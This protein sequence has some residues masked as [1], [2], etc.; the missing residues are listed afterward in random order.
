MMKKTRR[1]CKTHLWHQ[2]CQTDDEEDNKNFSNPSA[3]HQIYITNAEEF[4]SVLK[5]WK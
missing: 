4:F 5:M 2:I 1:T 3:E